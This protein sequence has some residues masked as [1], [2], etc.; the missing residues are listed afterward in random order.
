MHTSKCDSRFCNASARYAEDMGPL[1]PPRPQMKSDRTLHRLTHTSDWPR[2]IIRGVFTASE[3]FHTMLVAYGPDGSPI[4]AEETPLDQLRQLSKDRQLFCPNCRGI[5]HIRGGAEKRTQ[6]HFAHQKGE[7]AWSTEAESVRHARGK[8]VLAQ[9]LRDQF[10]YATVSLEERLPE[11]NRIADIFV[12]HADKRRWAVEFQCA[13]LDIAEW[14]IR[15]TAYRQAGI[16]DIWIIGTNRREKQEA[17][18]EAIITTAREVMF[19]DPQVIPP[20][21]W[22]R[23]PLTQDE[24][25]QWQNGTPQHNIPSTLSQIGWV[26]HTGFG[27]TLISSLQEIHCDEHGKLLHPLK[28]RLEERAHLVQTMQTASTPDEA[29]LAAYLHNSISDDD[30]RIVIIPLLHAYL[31]DPQLLQRYNYGR[32]L[33][34]TPP[35]EA[36][37]ARIHKA[38]AWLHSLTQRGYSFTRLQELAQQIPFV[39][40]YASFASYM[41]ILL[42]T[43]TE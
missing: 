16:L 10:P 12:L 27:A 24:V 29:T 1:P 19:L 9:W 11:P 2:D 40:P 25:R 21:A 30:L 28:T 39:G 18:I 15:H 37:H 26:G 8:L 5:V 6:L 38:H 14:T 33:P 34:D 22:L 32:G 17:F 43:V 23:W 41:E 13:P 3:V 31:R 7:C 20:R 42:A 4:V 36:D 35:D